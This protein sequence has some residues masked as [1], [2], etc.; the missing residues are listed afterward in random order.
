M[1]TQTLIS[2]TRLG[3]SKSICPHCPLLINE[4]LTK[5]TW[6]QLETEVAAHVY[7][8]ALTERAM[9]DS[10]SLTLT[11]A[12][13]F[14]ALA[15]QFEAEASKCRSGSPIRLCV[16][17]WVRCTVPDWWLEIWHPCWGKLHWNRD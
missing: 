2:V 13:N 12:P 5:I 17:Q 10:V 6:I 9:V 15:K 7:M 14:T 1:V 16:K 4:P 11:V 3:A 8:A